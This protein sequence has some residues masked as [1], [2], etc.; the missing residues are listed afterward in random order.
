MAACGLAS[1]AGETVLWPS[2]LTEMKAQSDSTLTFAP[3]GAAVVVT[4]TKASWPGM[5][6]DFKSGTMDLSGYGRWW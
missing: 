1:G 4:G 2:P 3:D 5:R 6:M